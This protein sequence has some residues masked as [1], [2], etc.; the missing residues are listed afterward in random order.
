MPSNAGVAKLD[1]RDWSRAR[2]ASLNF[3][4][5]GSFGHYCANRIDVDQVSYTDFVARFERDGVPAVLAGVIR[6]WEAQREWTPQRLLERFHVEKFKVGED[7]DGG[8]RSLCFYV[9]FSYFMHYCLSGE[10]ARDDSPLYIF[11][12]NFGDRKRSN[13]ALDIAK[14][15]KNKKKKKGKESGSGGGDGGGGKDV[16]N[17]G[18]E[19]GEGVARKKD[20]IEGIKEED[21]VSEEPRIPPV[22]LKLNLEVPKS[23]ALT[24]A[25]EP[26]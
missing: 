17:E 10:A 24:S 1:A 23:P 22:S 25:S 8:E 3:Q 11:D 9:Q 15:R 4:H 19:S 5:P 26:D 14:K 13:T 7:D 16:E 18:S 20:K 21:L 2:F 6:D 12:P